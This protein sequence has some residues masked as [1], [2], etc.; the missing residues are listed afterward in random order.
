MEFLGVDNPE[1]R[2]VIT[3]IVG[4]PTGAGAKIL[5][6]NANIPLRPPQDSHDESEEVDEQSLSEQESSNDASIGDQVEDLSL[7][8]EISI[9]M[10]TRVYEANRRDQAYVDILRHVVREAQTTDFPDNGTVSLS[11][12][13]GHGASVRF[14]NIFKMEH[15]AEDKRHF[16]VGAAGELFVSAICQT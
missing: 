14:Q 1:A 15:W 11:E 6:N 7:L 13:S 10:R 8:N 9:S 4:A 12:G 3:M 5:M 2:S 16:R